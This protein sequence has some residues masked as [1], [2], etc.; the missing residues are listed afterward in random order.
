MGRYGHGDMGK[1]ICS[2]DEEEG[3]RPVSELPSRTNSM[4]SEMNIN[5]KRYLIFGTFGEAVRPVK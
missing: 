5:D 2:S 4:M 1:M 3:Y